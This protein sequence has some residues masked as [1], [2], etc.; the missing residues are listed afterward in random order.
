MLRVPDQGRGRFHVWFFEGASRDASLHATPHQSS[1]WQVMCLTGVDYFST[2]GYQPGIAF[3]A[4][5]VLSPLATIVLVL[6]TIFGALPMYRRIAELSPHGQG[7]IQVLE[8][9][10]PRW[11][12][13]ALVL[14]LLGFAAT[15][16]IITITLSAADAAAH[17]IENPMAP[18][19]M[20][21]PVVMTLLLLAALGGIFLKGFREAVGL[22]VPI[23]AVYLILNVILIGHEL[24]LV[25]A[26]PAPFEGWYAVARVQHGGPGTMMVFALLLFPR[27]ALGLSGFETGVAVMP[28]VRGDTDDTERNPRG[29][30]RNAKKLLTAAALIMSVL[31]VGSSIVTTRLV[32]PEAFA[33]GGEAYG[34]ALAYLA[35]LHL[36]ETFGTFYDLSTVTILW[37]AGA[38]ALVGLLNLVPRYLPRYGMA[39]EWAKANRPLVVIFTLI[40]FVVTILFKADVIAQGGAYAT[41]V[42]V[43]MGSAALAVTLAARRDGQHYAGYLLLTLIFVY[44]TVINIH[45]RPEGLKIASIFIVGIVLTSLV[46]RVMRSTELRVLGVS[47]DETAQAFIKEAALGTVRI[48]ANRPDLGDASEYEHK[49]KEAR[50]SHHLPPEE[51]PLF[52]EVRPSDVSAF[53]HRLEVTGVDVSGHH[54]LRCSSPAIPN[55]IAALLLYIRDETGKIPH[56][57]FGWTEGNPIVYLMKFLA[58]GEGD[59]APVA[60]EVLRQTEPN[61]LRRPRIHV[62]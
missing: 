36:G 49:L 17:I 20:N 11:R 38:S 42:L 25:W 21:H 31:L 23:V 16:F 1:W 9:L 33:E 41:G 44:T 50:E 6:L 58:F 53:S 26:Q 55:A 32:P 2:L 27:L 35:H 7:S 39:P 19:S 62:G 3:L 12:G 61:P 56:A 45:D 28:L 51:R 46:S 24:S 18:A 43:L 30:I 37:F 57:Y 34:R 15:G 59:T 13:K 54:V 4:A 22:A 10:L 14:C 40:T 5:G 60:R 29:R 52:V 48:I 8:E 47:A